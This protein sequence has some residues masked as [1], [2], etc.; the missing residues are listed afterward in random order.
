MDQGALIPH[1]FRSESRKLTAVLCKTFGLENVQ[2]AED[3][4]SDT[5]L[6]ALEYWSYNGIPKDPVAWLYV[7]AKNQAKNH[8]HRR[9]IYS[10]K[11]L[12]AYCRSEDDREDPW[13]DFSEHSIRDSQLQMLFALC[14]PQITLEGQVGL[15]LRLLCGFGIE[16]IASAFLTRKATI[17]KRLLR[18]KQKLRQ[19]QV[20]FSMPPDPEIERRMDAVLITI[21]LLFSEGYHSECTDQSLREDLCLEA[22]RL[23][24]LLLENEKTCLPRVHALHALM[25]FHASRFP[26]RRNGAQ[27]IILYG[28]QDPS[29][30]DQA[31]IAKGAFYMREAAQGETLSRYHLEAAIAWWHTVREDTPHKWQQILWLYDQLLLILDSPVVALNRSY[32]FYRVHGARAAREEAQKWNLPRNQYYFLLLAEIFRDL[33]LQKSRKYLEEALARAKTD[34]EKKTIQKKLECI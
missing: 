28:D 5:F 10:G 32:A 24:N 26:A 27:E 23:T 13:I 4:T 17:Q 19:L 7:V 1:L 9:K 30:W 12:P 18:A 2:M 6:K 25:C 3:I 29:L 22:M 33:D 15:A 20:N 34:A 11:V 21:Y 16:E 8:L 14:H 31:L